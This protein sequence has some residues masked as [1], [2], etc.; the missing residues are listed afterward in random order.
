MGV[1]HIVIKFHGSEYTT[2]L[3]WCLVKS[4]LNLKEHIH[5]MFQIPESIQMISKEDGIMLTEETFKDVYKTR[6]TENVT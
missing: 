4:L 1:S 3:H 2:S 6:Y 5:K